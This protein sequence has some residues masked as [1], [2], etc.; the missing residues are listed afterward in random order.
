M[1][2]H[3]DCLPCILRQILEASRTATDKTELQESIMDKAIRILGQYRAFKNSPEICRDMHQIVKEQ[4]GVIDPYSEIKQQDLQ[5][6]I[7][8]YPKLKHFIENNEDRLYWALK[9]AATGNVLDSAIYKEHDIEANLDEEIKKPF[10]VCDTSIF[11]QQ[12]KSAKSVLVIGD[13][14]GETVFDCLLLGQ[15][16]DYDLTYAVRDAPVIN[17]AT[18]EEAR[19][20]GID[21][22]A[23]IISTGCNAPGVLMDECSKAFVDVFFGADIVISKGQGNYES[24]SD[25]DR[26]IYFLLKAKC[27]VL[28]GQI[29]VDLNEYVFK[30]KK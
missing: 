16:T 23:R 10:A 25:C 17:D 13:N 1:K 26:N 9:A 12:L 2:I 21:R 30:Y 27:A 5:T 22:Y 18:I 20:S 15:L 3:L 19:A 24:L 4:T 29:D 7:N 6:A 14:T 11:N 28:A 8:L